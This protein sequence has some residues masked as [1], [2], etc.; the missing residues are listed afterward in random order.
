MTVGT[1]FILIYA[2]LFYGLWTWRHWAA[3]AWAFVG[4]LLLLLFSCCN[5]SGDRAQWEEDNL[6]IR[7]S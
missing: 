5:V 2:G 7:R 1:I 3:W 6:G 4:F